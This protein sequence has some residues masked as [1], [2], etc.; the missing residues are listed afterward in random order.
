MTYFPLFSAL[1]N[2]AALN[3]CTISHKLNG[4]IND[5]LESARKEAVVI[6]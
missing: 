3:A 4:I 2:K 5:E 6:Y 1:L